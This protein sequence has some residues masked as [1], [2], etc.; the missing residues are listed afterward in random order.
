MMMMR[1]SS[2]SS[3]CRSNRLLSS[4]F[5]VLSLLIG[6][7]ALLWAAVKV[8]AFEPIIAMHSSFTG[9]TQLHRNQHHY[10]RSISITKSFPRQSLQSFPANGIIQSSDVSSGVR[11]TAVQPLSATKTNLSEGNNNDDDDGGITVN[12]LYLIPWVGFFVYAFLLSPGT[13]MDGADTT[14][15]QS[16]IVDPTN[17]S[18]A[19]NPLYFVVFNAL[20]IMPLVLASIVLPQGKNT[21]GGLWGAGPFLLASLAAGYGS[22]GAYMSLRSSPVSSKTQKELSWPTRYVFENKLYNYAVVI[23]SASLLFTSGLAFNPNMSS[24]VDEYMQLASTSKLVAVSSLDLAI[25]T[26]CAAS[27]IP[28]DYRLRYSDDDESSSTANLVA[29]STLL[30]PLIGAALYCAIRPPLQEE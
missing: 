20:G 19:I 23:L 6:C 7:G 25:L 3:I 16:F 1:S 27:L 15:I 28:Q 14:I 11:Y 26:V 22:F 18:G 12:P 17:L 13:V 8:E 5:I 2:S 9:S 30:V 24:I 10:R 4:I 21:G 29:A